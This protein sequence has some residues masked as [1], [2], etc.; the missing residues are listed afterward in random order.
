MTE[1]TT[2]RT[3]VYGPV[4]TVVW[5]G[6]GRK[7]HPYPDRAGS[8]APFPGPKRPTEGVGVL[9]GVEAA[10]GVSKAEETREKR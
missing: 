6:L 5:E 3:A 10:F 2:N 4:R 1:H 8:E 7:A 9:A